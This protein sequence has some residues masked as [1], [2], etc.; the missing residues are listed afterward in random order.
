MTTEYI[1][2]EPRKMMQ[3]F[4]AYNSYAESF[5]DYARLIS[6][7]D[8]YSDVVTAP[9]AEE[10]ARRIQSAGY[11]TDPSYADKLISIMGY[12]KADQVEG[13]GAAMASLK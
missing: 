9:T 1:D 10:A 3:P 12:F 6:T 5:A 7:A 11:A 13:A 8:R 2:G 4:R